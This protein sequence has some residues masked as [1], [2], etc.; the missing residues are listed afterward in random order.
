MGDEGL[1]DLELG[2]F[3]GAGRFIVKPEKQV[4][5]EYKVSKVVLGKS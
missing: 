5:V 3:V 4:V 1:K 2:V